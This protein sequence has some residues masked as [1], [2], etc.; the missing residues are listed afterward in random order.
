[1]NEDKSARYHRLSRRLSVA[2]LAWTVVFLATVLASGLSARLRDAAAAV[3]GPASLTTALV[4]LGLAALHEPVSL[5]LTWYRGFVV[6]HR[7]GLSRQTAAQWLADHAK[8]ALVGGAL[9]LLLGVPLYEAIAAWPEWW[10]LA[11]GLGFSL[12]MVALATLAPVLVLPLFFRFEPLDHP[13]LGERLRA[14][15]ERAGAKI[16]GVYRWEL[17]T[18]TS[19]A[20][21]ALTGIG[22]TRRILIADTML[23]EYSEDE[24]EVVLAHELAHHVHRDIWSGIALETALTVAGFYLAHL[25]LGGLGP[26]FGLSGPADPA[27]LPLLLLAAGAVSLLLLPLALAASRRHERRADRFALDLTAK[28][29]AFVTAMKRLGAQNLAEERPSRVVQWLFYSHPPLEERIAEAE[30]WTGTTRSEG[31]RG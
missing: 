22:G 28:P 11:A 2:S 15:A 31:G 14:L 3:G 25:A 20:N 17:A 5:L 9:A 8:G 26:S 1:M 29:A 23:A 24:I 18:K 27:G 30:G 6:E 12:V 19:K 10:W 13:T 16:V 21:A 4:I 7:Y